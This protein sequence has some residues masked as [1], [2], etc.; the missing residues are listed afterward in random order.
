MMRTARGINPVAQVVIFDTEFTAWLG[1]MARAW[2]GPGEHQEIVQIGAV[3]LCAQHMNELAAF[4][5]L[6]KPLRNP[7]LST[8]FENLTRITNQRLE[9][10][11]L[12][13]AVGVSRFQAFASGDPAFC[14]G[15]DDLII[16]RNAALLGQ[17]QLWQQQ[18]ACNL[19]SWLQQVGIPLSGIHAGELAA[20]V[21]A[22]AQGRV[23]DSLAD[24]RSLAEAIRYL[25][26]RGAPN[27][28]L[29]PAPRSDTAP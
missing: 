7:V 25:V 14:Y 26:A 15:R 23:H 5:V 28:F 20:H 1:S 27:P 19:R 2:K 4:S 22:A 17:P 11:G 21:G 10:E 3:K 16:A 9:Q 29:N 24:A 18:P 8:Y 12:P 13:F 6:I